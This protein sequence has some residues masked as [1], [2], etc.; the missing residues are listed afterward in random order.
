MSTTPTSPTD[1]NGNGHAAGR[2][3][4]PAGRRRTPWPLA[5]VAVLFVVVPFLTWYWTW[6]GRSLGDAELERYLS[7]DNPRH[8]QHAL[9]QVA[10]KIEKGDAGAARWYGRVAALASSPS[11]DVR[12]T[13]AWVMGLEHRSDEFRAALARL[14]EDP[15]PIVRRNAALALV[16]FGDTRGRAELVAMLRPYGVSAQ[17][18]GTA[19]T[20]LTQ[21]S[22]VK[23]E[24][25]L[26]KY[27]DAASQTGEVRS[28]LPGVVE[29][30]LVKDG[31]NFAAGAEL[32]TLAPDEEQ[33]RDALVGLYYV[34][35]EGELAE[36]ERY[37]RGVEGMPDDVKA[38]AAQT[39]E[40]IKRRSSNAR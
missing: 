18:A 5:V 9:S 6:F 17:A 2:A 37:A 7:E 15:E 32:F 16:R 31:E 10:E 26:L 1:G 23:R 13:A 22:R 12:M 33:A 24:S 30:A 28:P 39:A 34:G 11:P 36:V 4:A 27:R 8:A 25:L 35:G 40:A 38:K 14:L 19:L 21:G 20:A 29:K 3:R